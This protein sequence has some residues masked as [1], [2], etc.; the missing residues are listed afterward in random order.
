MLS[1]FAL[2]VLLVA[3]AAP[4]F[5]AAS[6]TLPR[7]HGSAALDYF[8]AEGGAARVWIPEGSTGTLDVLDLTTKKLTG[9][10]GFPAGGRGMNAVSLGDGWAFVGNRHAGE[11]CSVDAHALRKGGCASLSTGSD[12]LA[13]VRSTNE[14]WV[15]SPGD[16]AL[17]IVDARDPVHPKQIARVALAGEPEGYAVDDARA[18]FFTN[19]EDKNQTLAVDVRGRKVIATWNARCGAGGPR[20]LAYDSERQFLFV[21]CTDGARVLDARGD[22]AVLSSL[23][24]GPGVDNID[25]LGSRRRLYVAAGKAARLTVA[26][27]SDKGI[28]A[29]VASVPTV[30]GARVVVVAA[31]GMAVVGDPAHGG[32]LL[33]SPAR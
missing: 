29:E 11:V 33:L 2:S 28:L 30:A 10:A 19:L 27:V 22:G 7:V 12:G 9:I 14:V 4:T 15:T 3:D 23:T 18:R 24:A 20:G 6:V 21:A 13:Y 31:D 8:A 1:L 16:H 17:T 5:E 26:E 32:V 25:Y